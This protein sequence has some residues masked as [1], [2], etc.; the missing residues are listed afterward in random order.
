MQTIFFDGQTVHCNA[1][2]SLWEGLM[3]RGKSDVMISKLDFAFVF[4]RTSPKFC[5]ML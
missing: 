3:W 2:L 4:K 5:E 1:R